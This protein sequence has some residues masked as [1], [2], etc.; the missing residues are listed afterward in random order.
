MERVLI[1]TSASGMI[2]IV[3]TVA[4]PT[5]KKK[6]N[7]DSNENSVERMASVTAVTVLMMLVGV[8]MLIMSVKVTLMVEWRRGGQ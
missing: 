7:G 4:V 1:A 8:Q 6:I 2:V 3:L 5:P